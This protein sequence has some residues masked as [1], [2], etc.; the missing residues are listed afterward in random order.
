MIAVRADVSIVSNAARRFGVTVEN[1]PRGARLHPHRRHVVR[2]D[3]VQFARDG[4]AVQRDGLRRAEL[5]LTLQLN[6]A[7]EQ[8]LAL[9]VLVVRA[10]TEVVRAAEVEQVDEDLHERVGEE[11]RARPWDRPVSS[12]P[13][14]ASMKT[15]ISSQAIMAMLRSTR[16][17]AARRRSCTHAP[18]VYSAMNI[19]MFPAY[20]SGMCSDAAEKKAAHTIVATV[21]GYRRR[22][23]SGM[24]RTAA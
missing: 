9:Q 18:T 17:M 10:V 15:E 6:R 20:I 11:R 22:R 21:R 8:R 23:A 5:A 2:D 7:G 16:T 24:A 12:C 3:V 14:V 4:D 1:R 19:A 13:L